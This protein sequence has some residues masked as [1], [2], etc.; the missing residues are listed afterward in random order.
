[1]WSDA[2]SEPGRLIILSGPSGAGKSSVVRELLTQCPLPLQL[3]VS[4]TT[5][6]PRSGE[7]DGRDYHFVSKEQFRAMRERGEF[8]ECKEVFEMGDWYGTLRKQVEDSLA[9]G[10]WMILEID[11]QGALSVMEKH[12]DSLSFFIRPESQDELA[13]RLRNRGTDDE[14]AILRRLEV[15]AEELRALPQ[16]KYEIVNRTIQQS[17]DDICQTLSKSLGANHA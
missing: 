15:A 10:K 14:Q 4:A 16:Y 3:S 7:V 11:V 17:V 5:R 13:N 9:S 12:R 8:L 6:T 1:M 2:V